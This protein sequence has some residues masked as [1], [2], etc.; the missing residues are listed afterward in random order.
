LCRAPFSVIVGDKESIAFERTYKIQ[1]NSVEYVCSKKYLNNLF[2]AP[3]S[4]QFED[5]DPFIIGR[6]G[7]K[8][9]AVRKKAG[10][11]FF[12]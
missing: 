1:I 12:L 7:G 10:F 5:T 9:D 11:S 8:A 4:C 6:D 3:H 2:E